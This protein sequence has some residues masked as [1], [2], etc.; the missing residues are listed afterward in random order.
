VK[1][2]DVFTQAHLYAKNKL[3]PTA[4]GICG[5]HMQ[6]NNPKIFSKIKFHISSAV[7]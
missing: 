7:A 5:E 6:E 4:F 2:N 1:F 3:Y